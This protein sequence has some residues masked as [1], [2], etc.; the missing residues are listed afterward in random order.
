MAVSSQGI[1]DNLGAES[2]NLLAV[3]LN[4]E[5]RFP[6]LSGHKVDLGLELVS[7]DTQS[8]TELYNCFVWSIFSAVLL[9]QR[10]LLG[11]KCSVIFLDCVS[12]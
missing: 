3:Y 9:K 1:Q 2:A 7:G 11:S 4:C 6:C 10:T 12:T 5:R 8:T